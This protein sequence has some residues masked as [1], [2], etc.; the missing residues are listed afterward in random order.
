M[1]KICKFIWKNEQTGI[2]GKTPLNS[3]RKKGEKLKI[4]ETNHCYFFVKF[5]QL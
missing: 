3:D 2:H 1:K 5:V 4:E